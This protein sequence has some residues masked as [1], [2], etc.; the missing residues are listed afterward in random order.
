MHALLLIVSLL[1][2]FPPA[3]PAAEAL[4]A[5]A[6]RDKLYVLCSNADDVVVVDVQSLS[7][8][9]EIEVGKLPHGIAAT[10]S[11]DR[12]WVSTEGDD[13]LVAIDP[14]T[15]RVLKRYPVG[16]RPNEIDVTSDGRYVYVPALGDGVYEVFDT[17]SESIVARIPTDGFPHNVV[18]SPDDRWAYLSP[19]DRGEHDPKAIEAAGFPASLNDK[20]Y[21][22]DAR[23]HSVSG[24]IPTGDAPRPIAVAPDGRRLFVN[25]DGLLGFLVL[26]LGSRR[27][28]AEA[29]YELTREER[30]R[31]SRAHGIGV[32]PDGREVWS[33][34]VNSGVVHVFDVTGDKPRPIARLQ[35]GRTPLWLTLTPDGKTVF[36]ANTADDTVSVF[37]VASKRERMRIPFEA[38]KGPKRMLVVRVPAEI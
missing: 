19:T 18:I 1:L 21:V 10:R 28:L 25:R 38:G 3:L 11:G 23:N 12:L 2:A 32:T 6:G 34:D 24:T 4:A 17:R 13:G 27:T 8:V 7:P 37:D 15:D 26:D 5:G 33:T 35:T 9:S 30:S 14:R 36:V 31:P 22:V 16:R 29:R 20:I